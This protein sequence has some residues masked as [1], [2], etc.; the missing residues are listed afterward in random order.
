MSFDEDDAD[1]TGITLELFKA[2]LAVLDVGRK[3][4]RGVSLE[5]LQQLGVYFAPRSSSSQS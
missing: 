2:R 5:E 3:A 1:D 4:E